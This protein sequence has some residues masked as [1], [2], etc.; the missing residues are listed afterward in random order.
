MVES[1]EPHIYWVQKDQNQ[2]Y[3]PDPMFKIPKQIEPLGYIQGK[4]GCLALDFMH[5]KKFV[6]VTIFNDE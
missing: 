6:N 1:L 3:S 5:Y 4:R 2:E